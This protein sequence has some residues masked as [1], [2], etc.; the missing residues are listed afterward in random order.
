[1]CGKTDAIPTEGDNR[2]AKATIPPPPP[3]VGVPDTALLAPTRPSRM[4]SQEQQSPVLLD[5][6]AQFAD[7]P[8]SDQSEG[9]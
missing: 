1:M 9:K 5:P 8:L 3:P 6:H 4:A 7:L 2:G